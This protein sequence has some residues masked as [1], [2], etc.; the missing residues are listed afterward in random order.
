MA[1]A[2]GKQTTASTNPIRLIKASAEHGL[3]C[4]VSV[5][6]PVRLDEG[7]GETPRWQAPI[8]DRQRPF[9]PVNGQ[10]FLQ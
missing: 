4:I 10:S 5:R 7:E 9:L 2:V 1:N 3:E 6:E 8:R